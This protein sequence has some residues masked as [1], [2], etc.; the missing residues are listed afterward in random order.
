MSFSHNIVDFKLDFDSPFV[1]KLKL[2][3]LGL[4]EKSVS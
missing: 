4:G 2:F 1:H 3:I